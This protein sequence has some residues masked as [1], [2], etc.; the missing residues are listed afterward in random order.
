MIRRPPRSTLFPYTTLFRSR[1]QVRLQHRCG[2]GRLPDE[3][4][5]AREM[6]IPRALGAGPQAG[7]AQPAHRAR[8]EQSFRVGRGG[9]PVLTEDG[10]DRLERLTRGLPKA[11]QA[12][13]T[14]H[15]SPP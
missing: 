9:A 12:L 1:H 10:R 15:R 14:P 3:L 13:V 11:P 4:A 2:P 8:P 6:V 5:A 7:E